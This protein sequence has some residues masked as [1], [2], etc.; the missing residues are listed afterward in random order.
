MKMIDYFG[1]KVAKHPN[2]K[3]TR[4]IYRFSK[5]DSIMMDLSYYEILKMSGS[6]SDILD[7]IKIFINNS[8]YKE[9][10]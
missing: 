3:N 5:W 7:I 10:S 1:Y 8:N 9:L 4:A 6:I 2:N